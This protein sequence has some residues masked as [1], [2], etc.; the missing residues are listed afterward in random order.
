MNRA[1]VNTFLLNN[2]ASRER[3]PGGPAG[4]GRAHFAAR[5]K[6]GANSADEASGAGGP[7]AVPFNA[8]LQ[9]LSRAK[10]GSTAFHVPM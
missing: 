10:C 7:P 4:Q 1:P 6:S 3:L 5:H 8:G 9:V 2:F